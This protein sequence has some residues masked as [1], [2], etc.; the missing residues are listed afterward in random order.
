[1]RAE[2][3][4]FAGVAAFFAVT[5]LGYAFWSTLEPVGTAVLIVSFLMA[6]LISFFCW[7][8]YLAKGRRLQDRKEADIYEAAGPLD[9]FPAHSYAPV[10]TALGFSVLMTGLVYYVWVFLLG[11]GITARG[12]SA[13]VF[14]NNDRSA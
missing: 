6:A 8:Q 11:L 3:F 5:G 14:E 10:I 12:V 4:L 7:R 1:V 9:F 2:S 13:F